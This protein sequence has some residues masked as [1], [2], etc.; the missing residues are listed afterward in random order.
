MIVLQP[1]SQ[2]N[3]LGGSAGFSVAAAACTPLM[4]QWYFD[5]T[6]LAAQTNSTLG[7]SNLSAGAA[8][9]YFA[10]VSASGG[11]TTSAVATLTVNL[12]ASSVAVAS[13]ENPAGFKDSLSFTARVTPTN[14][15]GTLQFLTNGVALDLQTLVA[16]QAVSTNVASLPRGTNIVTAI[17][18]GDANDLPATNTLAQIVTNHPPTATDAFYSRAAGSPLYIALTNLATHWSDVDGDTVSLAAV[19]VSTNGVT[20]TNTA[21]TLVYINSNNVADQFVCTISDGWGGTNFQTVN[22]SVVWLAIASVVANAG[23]SVTLDL[24]ATPGSTYILETDGEPCSPP[25]GCR[26][27]RTRS[28]RTASGSSPTRRPPTPSKASTA[29]NWRSD[30][31]RRNDL[32]SVQDG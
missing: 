17:Y 20:L 3:T 19:S 9:S 28:A 13:S 16:G 8:G 18:S 32:C 6:A 21:G 30:Q 22:I 25:A 31:R 12:L 10:V 1:Q 5:N 23:G 26:W 27:P 29:S 2:T 24:A 11:S 14:A 7:L 4:F 15:T